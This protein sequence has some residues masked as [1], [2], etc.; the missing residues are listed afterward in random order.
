MGSDGRPKFAEAVKRAAQAWSAQAA[1]LQGDLY[2]RIAW[3][4]NVPTTQDVDNIIKPILDALKGVVYE[5]DRLV[6]Q[7]LATRVNAAEEYTISDRHISREI[8]EQ[9]LD[10]LAED[11]DHILHV[12]VGPVSEQRV[13]FGPIDGG[14]S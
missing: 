13:T 9:L 11:C 10:L 3:F 5:D 7:C 14:A 8:H 2:T 12:E 4:H 1:L 6:S